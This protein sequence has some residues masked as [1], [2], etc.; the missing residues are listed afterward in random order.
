MTR[1][2]M[3]RAWLDSWAGVGHTWH[4]DGSAGIR[5]LADELRWRGLA[6]DLLHDGQGAR[7]DEQHR[8]RVAEETLAGRAGCGA[9]H[10]ATEERLT[11]VAK[12]RAHSN[13]GA[14]R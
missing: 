5:P 8:Q 10:A 3:V 4:W 9:R 14:G 7:A 11:A 12:P 6:R 2:L 13:A 1:T